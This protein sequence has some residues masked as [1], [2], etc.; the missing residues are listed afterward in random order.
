MERSCRRA[1]SLL[2]YCVVLCV[3]NCFASDIL[4]LISPLIG[5]GQGAVRN[6]KTF[7]N[8]HVN[9]PFAC[10]CVDDMHMG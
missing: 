5:Q 10:I 1:N 2:E 4:L 6:E 8:D 3:A 9:A 7:S